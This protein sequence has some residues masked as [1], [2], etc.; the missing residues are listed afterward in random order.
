MK[1]AFHLLVVLNSIL[2]SIVIGQTV[3]IWPDGAPG[4]IKCPA[5][6][7]KKIARPGG[8]DCIETIV[9][10]EI[11]V[12]PAPKEKSNGTA[13]LVCP[14]GGYQRVSI[15]LEGTEISRWLNENGITAILLKYRL[16]SD[17]IMTD[18]S[19]G[20]LQDAREAMRI[21]RRN[22]AAWSLNPEKIGIMG[23]SAGGHL[24][25]TL[26]THFEDS[27]SAN[28]DRVSARPD[29]S[30]F[31]YPVISMKKNITHGGSREK[32]LGPNPSDSLIAEY[33]NELHVTAPTPPAFL[34]HA[35]DDPSVPVENSL[36]YYL[37]LQKL[38]IPAEYHIYQSGG[39][40]F[41]L[42]LKSKNTESSWPAACIAWLKANHFIP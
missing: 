18:K 31:V 40:G 38:R 34:V 32:L 4:S 7:E 10:P 21:V 19:I 1:K 11:I 15:E 39:H 42:A 16:P 33:S 36:H 6:Q 3:K 12:Y 20:P 14:G 2:T 24:A 5:Y 26:C 35:S 22:A 28:T 41:G 23:F 27:I 29:F 9:D 25:S 13:I 37:A 30:I 17:S 8:R